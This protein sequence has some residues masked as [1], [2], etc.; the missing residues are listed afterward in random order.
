MRIYGTT[1]TCTEKYDNFYQVAYVTTHSI[2]NLVKYS[3]VSLKYAR[4]VAYGQHMT[5][6]WYVLKGFKFS[7][8]SVDNSYLLPVIS[9]IESISKETCIRYQ[10]DITSK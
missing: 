7:L 2:V 6:M 4:E 8:L 10:Y 5:H 9:L 3:S 1:L